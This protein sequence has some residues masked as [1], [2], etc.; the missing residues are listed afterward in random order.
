MLPTNPSS[1]MS[2]RRQFHLR[3]QSTHEV[4][5][6]ANP[7]PGNHR[8]RS[9][10]H[11]SQQHR[12]GMSL[13]QGLPARGVPIGFRPLHPQDRL[14]LDNTNLGLLHDNSQH[15]KQETQQHRPVQP[16]LQAQDFS[17]QLQQQLN[18]SLNQGGHQQ[19]AFQELQHHLDWYRNNFGQSTSP[20]MQAAS[21]FD[22]NNGNGLPAS[23][24]EGLMQMATQAQPRTM[25]NTPQRFPQAWPSPPPS[26]AKMSRSQSFQLDVTPMPGYPIDHSSPNRQPAGMMP[27]LFEDPRRNVHESSMLLQATAGGMHD[28]NDP[29]FEFGAMVMSPR[30]QMLNNLGPDIPASIIETGVPSYE[31]QQ[32]IG[33]LSETDKKYPCLW[34]GCGKKF[35]RKEN[36]RAH[37]QTHLGD[38]QFKC[39]LCDKTFVRQH[40]LKR[41]IAIHSSERPHSCICGQSF[42]RHDALTR[43]RQRGMCQGALPGYEKSEEDKPKR[44]R[45]KKERPNMD[46]RMKKSS[47][48]RKMNESRSYERGAYASSNYSASDRSFPVTPPD[49]SDAFDADAFLNMANNDVAFDSWKDT[50]PTSPVTNSPSKTI[51]SLNPMSQCFNFNAPMKADQGVSPAMFSNHSSPMVSGNTGPSLALGSSPPSMDVFDCASP[52]ATNGAGGSFC[53]GSSPGEFDLFSDNFDGVDTEPN[54]NND[55]FSPAGESNSG[56]STYNYSDC[57]NNFFES[58]KDVMDTDVAPSSLFDIPTGEM[59]A[60]GNFADALQSWLSAQ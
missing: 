33:E 8:Q 1:V 6:I 36:V 30:Q 34:E 25:P 14:Q 7:L 22:I 5:I 21:T 26:D 15:I 46:D 3:H 41:H 11:Q 2:T 35:G 27:T 20:N 16:G 24:P 39:N 29:S 54:A 59:G 52:A 32:Y 40:D 53:G 18:P 23:M 28:L 13:D 55:H 44:G 45:P 17:S 43:H 19:M 12:R 4:P 60:G 47:R 38:R 51:D 37:V 56:S 48:M 31:I 50:P 10:A 42:A 57:E 9:P 58:N 49:T